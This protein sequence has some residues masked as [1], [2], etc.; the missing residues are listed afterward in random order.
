VLHR[1]AKEGIGPAYL[2]G[3]RW[4]L[5]RRQ[6]YTHV[7]Q[8]D[9]DLSHDPRY[10]Q[11]LLDACDGGA[12]VAVGSRWVPGGGIEGWAAWRLLLSRGGSLYARTVLGVPVRDLTAGYKC[13]RRAVLA[14][15]PLSQVRT[16][17][18]GFQIEITYR[19]LAMGFVVREVP[20]VFPDRVRGASK[21]SL[22]IVSEGIASVWRL[23]R[24]VGRGGR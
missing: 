18:Y 10:L 21:M 4:A 11:D 24:T 13:F 9:A 14:A 16:R 20:I 19:A 2:A 15:L 7:I 1:P 6:A 22:K 23:R 8:M 17:G 5:D 3:Y 12:D